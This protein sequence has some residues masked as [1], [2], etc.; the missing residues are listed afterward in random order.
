MPTSSV[1]VY[2]KTYSSSAPTL[3]LSVLRVKKRSASLGDIVAVITPKIAALK[4]SRGRQHLLRRL[5]SYIASVRD[6]GS[7]V[8]SWCQTAGSTR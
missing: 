4:A 2:N 5:V 3:V 1:L 6:P 7:L 8:P